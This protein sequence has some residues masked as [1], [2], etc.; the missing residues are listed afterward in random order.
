MSVKIIRLAENYLLV[1]GSR[2]LLLMVDCYQQ[3]SRFNRPNQL[4]VDL[5]LLTRFREANNNQ[6]SIQEAIDLLI[7]SYGL[8]RNP[9]FNGEEFAPI[10]VQSLDQIHNLP[11]ANIE[12]IELLTNTFEQLKQS[13]ADQL[14]QVGP[15]PDVTLSKLLHFVQPISF[16]IL[17]SRVETILDIWGYPTTYAGFGQ[18]LCHLFSDP[19]FND[20]RTFIENKNSELVAQHP[21]HEQP[22]SLLK[23]ID[24]ILWFY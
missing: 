1:G 13:F 4:N 17:D 12:T 6:A 10:L 24:K 22:C 20:F 15:L 18:M 21:I 3:L 14:N 16:W 9:P 11:E 7:R 5:E 2:G 23:L 8:Q 19:D